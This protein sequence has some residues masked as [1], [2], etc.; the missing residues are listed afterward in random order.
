MK[1]FAACVSTSA[2]SRSAPLAHYWIDLG[3]K[4]RQRDDE[5]EQAPDRHDAFYART[6]AKILAAFAGRP[7]WTSAELAAH[8]G[9]DRLPLVACLFRLAV[10]GHPVRA[11]RDLDANTTTWRAG[12]AR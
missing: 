5:E 11:V 8:L 9:V 1:D 4:R 7:T 2:R 10:A 12:A 3:H 6:R